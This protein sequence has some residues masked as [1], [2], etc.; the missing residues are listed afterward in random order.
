MFD[1]DKPPIEWNGASDLKI[2]SRSFYDLD[3]VIA[4]ESSNTYKFVV[5]NSTGMKIKYN[6]YFH[7]TNNYEINMKYMLKKNDTYI[8]DTYSKADDLDIYNY[9]LNPGEVDTYYL[10]WK[11]IS[12][13]N[14][15]NIGQ[16]PEANYGLRIEVEAESINE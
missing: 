3:D 11:W 14:D 5:R 10:D 4:P 12:S 8:I 15:T 9:V 2:F 7:E 13:D 1:D 16:N 6:V